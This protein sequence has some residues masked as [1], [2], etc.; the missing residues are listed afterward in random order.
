MEHKDRIMDIKW[1]IFLTGFFGI[2]GVFTHTFAQDISR[3]Q[4]WQVQ[5]TSEGSDLVCYMTSTPENQEGNFKKRG[6]PYISVTHRPGKGSFNV[7]N[8]MAGYTY[9]EESEVKVFVV[10]DPKKKAKEFT[11]FTHNGGAWTID[12]KQDVELI[13]AMKSGV[14]LVIEGT[15]Q[16]GTTSKDTYS[17]NG[18]SAALKEMNS[19][20]PK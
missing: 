14:T 12:G 10:T 11:L 18:F 19:V 7:F 15:S 1:K 13:Q 16:K 6:N 17:L 5:K 9:K 3:H 2:I 4:D 20:C 8:V